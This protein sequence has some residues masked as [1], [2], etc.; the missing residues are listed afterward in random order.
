MAQ[1][2]ITNQSTGKVYPGKF[3]WHDLLTSEPAKAGQFYEALFGWDIEYHPNYSLVRNGDKL[4]AGIVKAQSAEQQARGGL[5]LPTASVADVD[6]TAKLVTAHGG[7]ILKGPLDMGQ[8]GRA[9]LIRDSQQADL[10]I[11]STAGGDPVDAEPAIGDWLWDELWSK[12]PDGI[13]PFYAAVF[14]YDQVLA[15]DSYSVLLR[16]KQWRAG[17]RLVRDEIEHLLWVPVIRV[18]DTQATTQR[19]AELGGSVKVASGEVPGNPDIALI[20]DTTGALL[21][22]QRWPSATVLEEL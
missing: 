12:D 3:I 7:K 9:M 13:E 2:P 5:W 18:A 17:I 1:T 20:A 4:I 15:N 21:L 10:L 19:V 14:G 8:R 22:I 11:L 6:A 16:D